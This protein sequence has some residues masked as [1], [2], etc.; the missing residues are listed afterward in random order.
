MAKRA[1]YEPNTLIGGLLFIEEVSTHKVEGKKVNRKGR[2]LCPI[3]NN[4]IIRVLSEVKITN[5][6]SCK[7]CADKSGTNNSN[8][9]H[10]FAY[11]HKSPE[12]RIYAGIKTRCYNPKSSSYDNYGGRGIRMH[13]RWLGRKGFENFVE[14]IGSRPTMQHSIDRINVNKNYEPGNCRWATDEEQAVNRRIGFNSSLDILKN[15]LRDYPK[16]IVS[17]EDYILWAEQQIEQFKLIKHT[18]DN[19]NRSNVPDSI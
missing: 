11:K 7:S 9:R 8:Y 19:T 14:D 16:Q 4:S 1:V 6:Q 2:F 13:P 15:V 17:I 18:Y 10:G 5:Q 3:C 12:Y